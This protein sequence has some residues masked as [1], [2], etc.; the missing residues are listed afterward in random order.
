MELRRQS[1]IGFHGHLAVTSVDSRWFERQDPRDAHLMMNI[2]DSAIS[3]RR[4]GDNVVTTNGTT[5]LVNAIVWSG[6][7]DQAANLGVTT[8]TYLTPLYGAVGS[9]AGTVS[10][11]DTLLF[12]ELGRVTVGAGASVPATPTLPAQF[13]WLFYFPNPASTWTI[14]EAGVFANGTASDA[15]VAV[16]GTLMDHWAF[17]PTVTVPTTDTAILQATFILTGM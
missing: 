6:I 2:P 14:T 17:S 10:A 7:Q 16:A 15:S 4:E 5:V 8:P 12:S 11:S 3:D 1:G 9:G 13:T